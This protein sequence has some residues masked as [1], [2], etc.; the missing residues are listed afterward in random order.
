MS[1]ASPFIVKKLFRLIKSR[2]LTPFV[3]D[4]AG[5]KKEQRE[6]NCDYEV[7][8]LYHIYPS[9]DRSN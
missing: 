1:R 3:E 6:E 8:R 4:S 7:K 9:L 2:T 5:R